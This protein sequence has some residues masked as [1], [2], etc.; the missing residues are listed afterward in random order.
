MPRS[1]SRGLREVYPRSGRWWAPG[2]LYALAVA[3]VNRNSHTE[4]RLAYTTLTMC[5]GRGWTAA[6]R[7]P[8]RRSGKC[9]HP[10]MMAFGLIWTV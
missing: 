8:G 4:Y 1:S 7:D 2:Y 5:T 10:P 3:M 9:R 6:L